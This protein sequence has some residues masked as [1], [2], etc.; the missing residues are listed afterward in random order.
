[1]NKRI[2]SLLLAAVMLCACFPV[3]ARAAETDAPVAVTVWHDELRR[4]MV[5]ERGED[6]LFRASDLAWMSGFAMEQGG[7]YIRFTRG[8]KTVEVYT[9]KNG[10]TAMNRG[11]AIA[12]ENDCLEAGGEW[13]L[14]GASVLPWLNVQCSVSAGVLYT[15][16]NP[17]SLWDHIADFSLSDYTFDFE[18]SCK[19][20]GCNPKLVRASS[21]LIHNG[22]KGILDLD[23]NFDGQ[24]I[25]STE[26][27]YNLFDDMIQDA[28]AVDAAVAEA[29]DFFDQYVALFSVFA[30][31]FPETAALVEGITLINDLSHIL[32]EYDTYIRTFETD[33]GMKLQ[34]LQS[35][36]DNSRYSDNKNMLSAAKQIISSYQNRWDN[37]R[38]R[39][40]Y[41]VIDEAMD[42]ITGNQ[43]LELLQMA[44]LKVGDVYERID[45][46]SPY[47]T[48]AKSGKRVYNNGFGDYSEET[49]RDAVC[50]AML[51]LY[52][53][54][55]NYRTMAEYSAVKHKGTVDDRRDFTA[56]AD[57]AEAAYSQLLADAVYLADDACDYASR[58]EA[59]AQMLQLLADVNRETPPTGAAAAV[60]A[61][62]YLAGL[63]ENSIAVTDWEMP[64][65]T[66]T[67]LDL[68]GSGELLC[69]YSWG[70]FSAAEYAVL[71]PGGMYLGTYAP[72]G[73]AG[74]SC[75]VHSGSTGQLCMFSGY[76]SAMNQ[77]ECYYGW[78]GAYW[79]ELA[80]WTT[81]V[82]I[83]A[84]G[85]AQQTQTFWV[86]GEKVDSGAYDD[87]VAALD[88]SDGY[89]WDN[90]DLLD[91][92][93][94]GDPFDL[95]YQIGDLLTRRSGF[96]TQENMDVNGDG[97]KDRIFVLLGACD[98]WTV[99]CANANDLFRF[100]DRGVTVVVAEDL[101]DRVRVRT[102]RLD[103]PVEYLLEQAPDSAAALADAVSF[104]NGRMN[105]GDNVF[106]YQDDG[107][108]FI[109]EPVAAEPDFLVSAE[110]FSI[111]L[112]KSWE[113][114]VDVTYWETDLT[115]NM[116]VSCSAA[117][118]Y[119]GQL[120][121]LAVYEDEEYQFLPSY[122]LLGTLKIPGHGDCALV[123]I[124]PTD[125]QYDPVSEA[126]GYY[127]AME[128][129]VPDILGTVSANGGSVFTPA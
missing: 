126:A 62:I 41:F 105:V 90:P 21:Y 68:D 80:A 30:A 109:R 122:A 44:D 51:Y 29:M 107:T 84:A 14:S 10:I 4:L 42:T 66:F 111:A 89:V 129:M 74:D 118:D 83:D 93:F 121:S 55:E 16:P 75:M 85:N 3:T 45:W 47:C 25:L 124:Y 34:M 127:M 117:G 65:W 53:V 2:L 60:E 11:Q 31:V 94:A 17:V 28:T 108:V 1:M 120:F 113:G 22:M 52:A 98:R 82:S 13:Y 6:L 8:S 76:Y 96:V 106:L 123:A 99:H 20:L 26:R 78:N 97:T 110:Y 12:M 95:F 88:P 69:Q 79:D 86:G 63:H 23:L 48:I 115:E 38:I 81:D 128:A 24:T 59:A 9:D 15:L 67:D 101:G 87:A 37:V 46:V 50:H 57:A 114:Y 32:L 91:Q 43:L 71:D 40:I 112:P 18:D 39:G 77:A 116:S 7:N 103:E 64:F 72:N 49:L 119:G 35:L 54:E 100:E 92:T 5:Y 33:H 73:A 70:G 27:Y 56:A 102:C 104:E 19:K 61:A 125:V 58:R 36:L